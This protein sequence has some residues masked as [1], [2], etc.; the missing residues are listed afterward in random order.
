MNDIRPTVEK[1]SALP[2]ERLRVLSHFEDVRLAHMRCGVVFVFA[3]WSGPA[4][5]GLQRFTRVM[6]SFDTRSLDL[7]VLD[8]DCLTADSAMQ[9]FG[10]D[11]FRAGG[12]GE[13]ILVRGGHIIA[14]EIAAPD[15]SEHLLQRHTKELL[16]DPAA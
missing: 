13:T 16:D 2:I 8:I 10:T 3:A 15:D 12:Y 5:I 7:V 9:L 6:S 1:H 4:V 14:R 11:G